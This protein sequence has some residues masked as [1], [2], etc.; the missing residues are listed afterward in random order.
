M[1]VHLSTNIVDF[2]GFDSSIISIY[3]GGIP[4]PI[5]DFL[6]SLTQAMLVGVMLVG[7]LDARARVVRVSSGSP[8]AP[9]L[10]GS[11]NNMLYVCMYI[12]IYIYTERE[13]EGCR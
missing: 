2:R 3:R 6:E 4:R 1:Y 9:A 12:Y 7:R 11:H 13:R 10:S 5:G 8:R